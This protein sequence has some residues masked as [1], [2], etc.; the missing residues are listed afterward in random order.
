MPMSSSERDAMRAATRAAARAL[1]ISNDVIDAW[2][3]SATPG[4]EAACRALL[5]AEIAHRDLT[6]RARL[7]RQ[8]RF[9]VPKSFDGFDRPDVRFPDGWGRDEMLSL[10]FVSAQS[11][12]R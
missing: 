9:P 1:F 7:L 12:T 2:V 5:E 3:A 11:D 6:R 4:Q 8:A 10:S